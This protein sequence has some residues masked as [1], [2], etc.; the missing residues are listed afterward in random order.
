MQCPGNKGIVDE[1]T[2]GNQDTSY[3]MISW[4]II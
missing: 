4:Q 1:M 3:V 2:N